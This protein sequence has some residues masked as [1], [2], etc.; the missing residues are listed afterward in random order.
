MNLSMMNFIAVQWL[1]KINPN[2]IDVIRVEFADDLRNKTLYETINK[3]SIEDNRHLHIGP[4][5]SSL[6]PPEVLSQI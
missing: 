6:E 5:M 4:K 3:L 1:E 2:L